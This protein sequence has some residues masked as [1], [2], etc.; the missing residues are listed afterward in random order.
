[1]TV[2]E[3]YNKLTE[4]YPKALS[5][6]WD[7]DGIMC[8]GNADRDVKRVLVA[9]DATEACID[10]AAKN[11]FDLVLT[12]H[13]MIFK[14]VKSVSS[15][16]ISGRNII[17]CV[18]NGISVISLHTRYDTGE[19]GVNQILAEMLKLSDITVFGDEES[20]T[21]G[22]IGSIA[23]MPAAEFAAY[24]RDKLGCKAVNAYF[25]SKEIVERIAV[26]GGGGKDFLY[27]ALLAGADV[28]ITGE[29]SYNYALDGADNGITTIEAG[30][31]ATEFPACQYLAELAEKIA[32]AEA[33][34]YDIINFKQI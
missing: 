24:V 29:C 21:L 12:H 34:I 11:G 1:M 4:L 27:P 6:S 20:P 5:C 8:C 16:T 14:G 9:L 32:G 10:H 17:S 30:H 33:E 15:E 2:T 18:I 23:P 25:S 26:V 13:P 22:R 19:N 31:Y 28:F 3:F 7:N